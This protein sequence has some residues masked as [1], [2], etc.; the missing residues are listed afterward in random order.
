MSPLLPK[1]MA[2]RAGLSE[3]AREYRRAMWL[4]VLLGVAGFSVGI[5]A[6][7][8]A[9]AP[10]LGTLGLLVGVGALALAAW[11]G[12]QVRARTL[13]DREREAS[14][15]LSV[16]LAAQLRD[17]DEATLEAMARRGGPAG[18]AAQLILQ[19]RKERRRPS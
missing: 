14:G 2:G 15:T 11:F 4:T 12:V 9:V 5:S 13:A 3:G 8:G 1:L 17:R 7:R 18:E 19:G 16:L 6:M 10:S